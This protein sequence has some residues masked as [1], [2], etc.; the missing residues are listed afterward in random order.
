MRWLE[1]SYFTY[2]SNL[3]VSLQGLNDT[4]VVLP[5]AEFL[6]PVGEVVVGPVHE[7]GHVGVGSSYGQHLASRDV[8][9]ARHLV[10]SQRPVHSTGIRR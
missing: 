7:A 5:E 3:L 2:I 9:V 10:Q 1:L 6:D 4:G 8:E